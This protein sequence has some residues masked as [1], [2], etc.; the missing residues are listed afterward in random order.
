M[1]I[2]SGSSP[3]AGSRP[4]AIRDS[5]LCPTQLELLAKSRHRPRRMTNVPDG[6][7]DSS[8]DSSADGLDCSHLAISGLANLRVSFLQ[9]LSLL[10]NRTVKVVPRTALDSHQT[11]PSSHVT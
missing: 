10:G 5:S 2:T 11:L 1:G 3:D 4:S 8:K 6:L 9:L 7:A